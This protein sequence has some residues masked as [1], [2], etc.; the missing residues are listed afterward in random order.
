[1][2]FTALVSSPLSALDKAAMKG[3]LS[4]LSQGISQTAYALE[5]K[6]GTAE[7]ETYEAAAATAE[8]A[9][10]EL[11]KMISSIESAGE[12]KQALETVN[13]FG[14]ENALQ[15][16]TSAT[17]LSMLKQ[18]AA[19]LNLPGSRISEELKAAIQT[20]S[21]TEIEKVTS[22][23]KVLSRNQK[24]LIMVQIPVAEAAIY[25]D[26]G[27]ENRRT[28]ALKALLARHGCRIVA[29]AVDESGEKP[30]YNNYISG[31]KFVLEALI[32][33]FKGTLVNSDLTA[34]MQINTGGFLS[35]K[36]AEITVTP[37]KDAAEKGSLAWYQA[38]LEK[39]PFK[40]LAE[41]QYSKLAS[42][43]KVETVG[44]ERKLRLKNAKMDIW[45]IAPNG[46]KRDAVYRNSV[47]FG[48]VYVAAQ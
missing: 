45:I 44:G 33:H 43:G 34:V 10:R 5:E 12:M 15:K 16:Q 24:R 35:P 36:T 2:I 26:D 11:A 9:E 25:L 13:A 23:D 37:Q 17:A 20:V 31:K 18:R 6:A 8:K 28:E 27:K 3:M 29:S 40:Y 41:T 48:D 46:T 21:A 39:D 14:Q 19:F 1:M 22:G 42:L 7:R 32:R 30:Q 47:D 4:D 38:V